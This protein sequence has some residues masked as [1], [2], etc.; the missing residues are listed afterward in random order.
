MGG[1]AADNGGISG[2]G[3]ACAVG[4]G[5]REG[6]EEGGEMDVIS[7]EGDRGRFMDECELGDGESSG[8][9]GGGST[10]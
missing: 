7:T 3:H 4:G 2:T 8:A 5:D 10:N 9:G 1:C 6:I